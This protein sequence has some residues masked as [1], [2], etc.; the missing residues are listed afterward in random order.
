MHPNIDVHEKTTILDKLCR[1][2]LDGNRMREDTQE[3]TFRSIGL[4][5]L[6]CQEQISYDNIIIIMA[7]CQ[8]NIM[9]EHTCACFENGSLLFWWNLLLL[10]VFGSPSLMLKL[11]KMSLAG[12]WGSKLSYIYRSHVKVI[13]LKIKCTAQRCADVKFHQWVS[14][15]GILY[16]LNTASCLKSWCTVW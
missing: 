12:I 16:S 6:C 10:R 1:S 15:N 13:C 3:N 5:R 2:I 14:G 11:D 9:C 8:L 7:A 4:F